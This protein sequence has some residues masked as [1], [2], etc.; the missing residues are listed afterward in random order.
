MSNPL[1]DNR[2]TQVVG[3]DELNLNSRTIDDSVPGG[4]KGKKPTKRNPGAKNF[5]E[6]EDQQDLKKLQKNNF[7]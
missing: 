6:D 3:Q 5:Q 4:Q 1:Q 2:R 7:V